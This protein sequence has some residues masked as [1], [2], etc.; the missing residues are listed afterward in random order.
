MIGSRDTLR[1]AIRNDSLT[2][3]VYGTYHFSDSFA[4]FARPSPLTRNGSCSK[5]FRSGTTLASGMTSKSSLFKEYNA[6]GFSKRWKVAQVIV[7][8]TVSPP[9][10]IVKTPSSDMRWRD[11]SSRGNLL[12]KIPSNMVGGCE[13]FRLLALDSSR[14]LSFGDVSRSCIAFN[15]SALVSYSTRSLMV[16]DGV[17]YFW[18]RP[19]YPKHANHAAHPRRETGDTPWR[20]TLSNGQ[21]PQ[22]L[23]CVWC[24]ESKR[25]DG[26]LPFECSLMI[27]QQ[28]PSDA[29]AV[30]T[31]DVGCKG[32]I[33]GAKLDEAMEVAILLESFGQPFRVFS[34]DMLVGGDC[35]F[36]VERV[37]STTTLAM[38]V[39][40]NG[41]KDSGRLVHPVR[42]L[43]GCVNYFLALSLPCWQQGDT[44]RG[45]GTRRQTWSKA[46]S[47]HI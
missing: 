32:K 17:L 39:M 28:V 26:V 8:A 21:K 45:S 37:D 40:W 31:N 47:G 46:I 9:A 20:Q 2:T 42:E 29:Q 22:H 25:G 41:T 19:Y 4:K 3:A 12:D 13:R 14:P 24:E 30:L 34:D 33:L 44:C 23:F 35:L 6:S 27:M 43:S 18:K 15:A 1:L 5:S 11:F 38:D 10:E 36:R 16:H 7:F